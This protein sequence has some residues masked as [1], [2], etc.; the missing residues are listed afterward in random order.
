MVEL[1]YGLISVDDH[2]QE[3]P[4][5]WTQRMS[6]ARWGERMPHIALQPDGTEGWLVDGMKLPM[7]GVASAG[8]AMSDRTREPQRWSEVPKVA[9]DPTARLQAMDVDGVDASVLYPTVAGLA[10]ETFGR[11]TDPE[12]ELACVQAYNDWLIEEWASTSLRFIPQ[13]IVPIFPIEATVQEIQRAVKK[14]HKGVIFPAIPMHLRDVPHIN[15]PVYDPL[16]ATCQDLAVPVCFHAGASTRVQ[17]PAYKDLSP[18][19]AAALAALTRPVSSVQ[20]V[21]N[22]LYSRILMRYPTLKVVFA[23]SSLAW[24]AYELETADHQFERQRLHLEGY[25]MKPSEM[26]H[27]QCYMT[28]WYDRSAI[29]ARQY[30]GVDNI[31]WETN[32]PQATSTWPTTRNRIAQSFQGVPEDDRTK[33]L[34][35]NATQLYKL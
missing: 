7:A 18:G 3:H 15:E 12:L 22:F 28:G 34:W 13:C 11:L 24:G 26:F 27:R 20:V 16:W 5:V 10:G 1:K 25:D 9:Y 23:E 21:A 2:V 29:E 32:F 35:G 4:E 8:A 31:L 33:M 19:L 14:G 30:L 17:F 6:R